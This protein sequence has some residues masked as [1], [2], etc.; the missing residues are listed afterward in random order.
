M[1]QYETKASLLKQAD[2]P[3]DRRLCGD[4]IVDGDC[5]PLLH[6]RPC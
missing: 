4:E 1:D 3:M 2:G 6:P 5:A